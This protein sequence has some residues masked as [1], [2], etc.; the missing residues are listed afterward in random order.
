MSKTCVKCRSLKSLEG[1]YKRKDSIDG[2]RADCK[3]CHYTNLQPLSIEDNLS[4]GN[5]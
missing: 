3:A 4:K 5:G 2:Y 1:F